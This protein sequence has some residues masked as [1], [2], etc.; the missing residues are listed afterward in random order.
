[1]SAQVPLHL[2]V[3]ADKKVQRLCTEVAYSRLSLV[4]LASCV[5]KRRVLCEE[6]LHLIRLAIATAET[7]VMDNETWSAPSPQARRP[8][9]TVRHQQVSTTSAHCTKLPL[10]WPASRSTQQ[11]SQRCV[12]GKFQRRAPQH[13]QRTA[14]SKA[15]E[16]RVYTTATN[17]TNATRAAN[18]C[19]PW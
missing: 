5:P 17:R 2:R 6:W 12:M 18:C 4:V 15:H 14:A 19:L 8:L 9:R 7:D 13:P 16:Q 10:C 1:V 3:A 11:D